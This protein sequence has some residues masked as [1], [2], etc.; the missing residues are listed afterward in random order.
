M[1]NVYFCSKMQLCVENEQNIF[2]KLSLLVYYSLNKMYSLTEVQAALNGLSRI[3]R[4]DLYLKGCTFCY[5]LYNWRISVWQF[6]LT[7][8]EKLWWFILIHVRISFVEV[9][10]LLAFHGP[11]DWPGKF[12][13][14]ITSIRTFWYM[15][16]R[17]SSWYICTFQLYSNNTNSLRTM[18]GKFDICVKLE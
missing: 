9:S 11:C 5:T 3:F 16:W 4:L 1:Q 18:Q 2:L 10:L 8:E 13:L 17:M 14:S 12:V 15:L 7:I 6:F